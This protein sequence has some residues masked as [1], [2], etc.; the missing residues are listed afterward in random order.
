MPFVRPCVHV[1]VRVLLQLRVVDFMALSLGMVASLRPAARQ[2]QPKRPPQGLLSLKNCILVLETLLV[3][4]V[5]EIAVL[6]LL[7]HQPWFRGGN[8]QNRCVSEGCQAAPNECCSNL[9]L[10]QL[11]AQQG[12]LHAP[13]LHGLDLAW[14]AGNTITVCGCMLH[15]QPEPLILELAYSHVYS[16]NSLLRS[17]KQSLRNDISRSPSLS[18]CLFVCP[19][20]CL[21]V[22]MSVCLSISLSVCLVAFCTADCEWLAKLN[23]L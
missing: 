12:Q 16:C 22:C 23:L 10:G 5:S 18:V 2:L 15:V 9:S 20:V 17:K 3:L 14:G 21:S 7:V 19:S 1:S 11:H 8:G 4:A 6:T 13:A